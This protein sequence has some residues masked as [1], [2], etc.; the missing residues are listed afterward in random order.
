MKKRIGSCFVLFIFL[1]SISLWMREEGKEEGAKERVREAA[2]EF[3][4]EDKGSTTENKESIQR[5]KDERDSIYEPAAHA[6]EEIRSL[7][8]LDYEYVDVND[9]KHHEI[10]FVHD[11]TYEEI[12]KAY[13]EI[14]FYGEIERGDKERYGFYLEKFHLLLEEKVKF[15]LPERLKKLYTEETQFYLSEYEE[16]YINSKSRFIPED[17]LYYFFDMNGDNNPELCI[18]KES[19]R[20]FVYIF[21]YKEETDE[22]ILW[23]E[24]GNGYYDL[25][26]T[27]KVGYVSSYMDGSNHGYYELNE[28][29]N[30]E[31][32]VWFYSLFKTETGEMI[33]VYMV[34]LPEYSDEDKNQKIRESI[35][36]TPY[37]K[38]YNHIKLYRV[39]K[40]QYEELTSDYFESL[41]L[42]KEKRKEVTYT[43]EEL[44]HDEIE[45]VSDEK[46]KEIN[47]AYKEIDFFGEFEQGDKEKK[48]YYQEKFHQLLKEEVKFTL[49]EETQIYLSE[50]EGLSAYPKNAKE[51]AFEPEAY[52]YSFYDVN[53]DGIPE[54]CI[55]PREGNLY[56]YIFQYIE[57][58]DEII[59]RDKIYKKY[60]QRM[61]T[62]KTAFSIPGMMS[63]IYY[64][65]YEQDERGEK[66]REVTFY[67]IY[68]T[69]T[70]ELVEVYMVE[71]PYYFEKEIEED[72]VEMPYGT[73]NR[74]SKYYRVTK[75]Q[76][77]ELTNDY[78]QA[79]EEAKENLKQVTYTYEEL[80]GEKA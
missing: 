10:E 65:F 50:Y 28:E 59:L 68:E 60:Y 44:F 75:E 1:V 39:T 62:K 22:I 12:K 31:S 3:H 57:E 18:A 16:L 70:G 46:F 43:Y 27:K 52:L 19:G 14:N 45:F 55:N 40:E 8:H 80:F 51:P 35:E 6:Y 36:E 13:E 71:M 58:T 76:Y 79:L 72:R 53:G 33:Y 25:I 77:E 26:G 78:F 48:E 73:S 67:S 32:E 5:V 56:Y 37:I 61:G 34:D 66:E 49:S 47:N 54:L 24:L 29:G 63:E 15:T 7:Y 64:G 20:G 9:L 11:K 74:R 69:K 21:Q 2:D 42:G 38:G 30:K 41:E 23:Y 17:Y 4:G